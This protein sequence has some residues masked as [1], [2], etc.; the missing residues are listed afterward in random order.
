V[1]N[2]SKK[3]ALQ[4]LVEV[5]QPHIIF[6][7]E[8][9]GEEGKI[10]ALLE[11]FFPLWNF[12]GS[13]VRGRSGVLALGWNSKSVKMISTWGSESRLGLNC[14]LE[15]IGKTFSVLNIY[16]PNDRIPFWESL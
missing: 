12:I 2:T 1:D 13:D 3:L 9:L 4:R 6:L 14:F 16:A 8:T 15:E 7:Q 5:Y 10:T 11:S